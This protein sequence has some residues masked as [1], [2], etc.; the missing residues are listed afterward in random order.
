MVILRESGGYICG[1]KDSFQQG[2]EESLG[3]IMLGRKYCFIRAVA[4]T[5]ASWI[6]DVSVNWVNKVLIVCP[7]CNL[8]R[9]G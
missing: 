4:P 9:D 5:E 8:D 3:E 2:K 1:S 7:C 6:R